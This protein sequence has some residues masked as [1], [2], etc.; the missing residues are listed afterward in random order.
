MAFFEKKKQLPD[1]TG[2]GLD[3]CLHIA[4]TEEDPVLIHQALSQAEALAPDNLE[5]QKKL[6]LLGRLHERNPKRFDFGV[7]KS[8]L[9]H[10][11]EHPE[12]H[13]EKKREDMIR[14]I[15]HHQRLERCLALA[16][17]KTAFLQEYLLD[18]SRDYMRLFVGGDNS[19][20]PRVFGFSFKGSLPKHLAA[21]AGDIISNILS[22][23]IL[24]EE[25]GKLLAKAFYR[26]FY[27]YVSGDVKELDKN[28]GPQVRSL[29]R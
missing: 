22:S 19:H 8:Y 16:E 18:L 7:I 4:D 20:V 27:D 28:L 1:L 15:F 10:A 9:L 2:V 12:D 29:L 6:L 3:E 25:Q 26:A 21:P 13:E 17:D 5:V 24:T 23:P 11:F 14:E